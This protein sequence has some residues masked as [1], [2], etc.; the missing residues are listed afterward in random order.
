[1]RTLLI[2]ALI[3]VIAVPST[4]AAEDMMAASDRSLQALAEEKVNVE[5]SANPEITPQPLGLS[6]PTDEIWNK[7]IF[8]SKRSN[9]QN[10]SSP[11]KEIEFNL[12]YLDKSRSSVKRNETRSTI[13]IGYA[14]PDINSDLN[15]L[16]RQGDLFQVQTVVEF[17]PER[18]AKIQSNLEWIESTTGI[19]LDET[20]AAEVGSV[21]IARQHDTAEGYGD[22]GYTD[23]EANLNYI[24]RSTPQMETEASQA[25]DKSQ[26]VDLKE[27][28]QHIYSRKGVNKAYGSH[29]DSSSKNYAIIVGI[30][31]YADRRGLHASVNDANAMASILN[32]YGYDVI[33]LTD[34]TSNKPTKHNILDGALAEVELKSDRDKVIFYFSGHAVV[35]AK[36]DFYLIPQDAD[37]EPSSYI[38]SEEL[39]RY[40]KGIKNLAVI[41]D[42][43][44]SGKFK[45]NLEKGQLAL[46]SSSQDEP[47][48][49]EWPGSFSVFTYQLCNA[50]KEERGRGNEISLQ[51]CFYKARDNTI[52]W[53]SLRLLKQT[54]EIID[55]TDGMYYLN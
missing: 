37:G 2:L 50:I 5:V 21:S 31:S 34:E 44:N 38:C 26:S 9:A 52:D 40:L 49:E 13:Q 53:S 7:M 8:S 19:P 47:S 33:K 48:N 27:G 24:Y 29:S 43:C 22:K 25:F 28:L 41:I 20:A 1:L 3:Y 39:T 35:D 32:A 54:P 12:K 23:I 42:A 10:L 30:N 6:E 45:Y 11:V 16:Y 15:H 14:P 36:G 18:D 55:M 4:H 51:R 17:D 46:T